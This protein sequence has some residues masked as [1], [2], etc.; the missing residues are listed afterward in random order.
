MPALR[1]TGAPPRAVALRWPD[2]A[3]AAPWALGAV[4]LGLILGLATGVGGG[5]MGIAAAL[6]PLAVVLVLRPDWLPVALLITVFAEAF[7]IGGVTISRAAGPLALALLALQIRHRSPVR[8]RELDRTLLVAIGAYSLWA[9]ASTL[10]S[11]DLGSIHGLGQ[12]TT[13]YAVSSL[14]LSAIY[15]F[16]TATLVS[17]PEHL[18]RIVVTVWALS[19]VMGIL[20]ILEYLQGQGRATGVS[21][22]ANF[23][24]TLQIVAIPLGAVLVAHTRS[25]RERS[26]VLL[27]VAI[28]VGSVI[29]TLSR[30]GILA[31]G[32]LM[33]MLAF[34]PASVFFRTKAVKR[35]FLGALAIGAI[36]LLALSFS[37]LSARTS[38]LFSTADG[39]SGRTNLWRGARTG[40]EQHPVFGLGFGAFQ[41]QSN[42]LMR[43]SPGVDF[44]AY[45]LRQGGQPV[46]NAYL[47]SLVE[48][49]PVGLALF[50]AMLVA[51]VLALRRAA[52]IAEAAGPSLAS[53]VPRALTLSVIGFALTSVLLSTETDRTLWVM[54]GLALTLPRIA[55]ASIAPTPASHAP[56]R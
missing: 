9:V 21:G 26:I 43:M 15:L 8:L 6:L 55:T 52:R 35:V 3:G 16:A 13:L 45:Q 34:Q 40:Y 32:A 33:L 30:G 20:A 49:G 56:S 4:A 27:G 39:G 53:A 50:L 44:S 48:L 17:R 28:A 51:T 5:G 19:T 25:A 14:V 24:A 37:A 11:V 2:P 29:V 31:L 46:H 12:G 10:W 41:S 1:V 54:M 22:D 23:F 36:L 18:M 42:D 47:E 7:T 38:S